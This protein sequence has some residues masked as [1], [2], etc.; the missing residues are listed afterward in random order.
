M[1][2]EAQVGIAAL[3]SEVGAG[4]KPPHSLEA[5][6]AGP[7]SAKPLKSVEAATVR[8]YGWVHHTISLVYHA[9]RPLFS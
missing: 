2:R 4:R 1:S 6:N 9:H 8:G 5:A 3:E 7:G